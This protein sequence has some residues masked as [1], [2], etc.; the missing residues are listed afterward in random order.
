MLQRYKN[1]SRKVGDHKIFFGNFTFPQKGKL[2]SAIHTNSNFVG[3][4]F[5]GGD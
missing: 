2:E 1:K 5:F 4:I 3:L